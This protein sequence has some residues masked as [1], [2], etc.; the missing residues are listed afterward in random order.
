MQARE[1][2]AEIGRAFGAGQGKARRAESQPG[3][4]G[5]QRPAQHPGR[6]PCCTPALAHTAGVP[7]ST[8]AVA[9]HS[10]GHCHLQ[11]GTRVGRAGRAA[12]GG[13]G[14]RQALAHQPQ[15][16]LLRP[17]HSAPHKHDS[18]PHLKG[19]GRLQA[20]WNGCVTMANATT[21]SRAGG[22]PGAPGAPA[23]SSS[24]AAQRTA[25]AHCS[26]LH[27][28]TAAYRALRG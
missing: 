23:A 13:S 9:R 10:C 7:H 18:L 11:G 26:R 22:A 21:S 28:T 15:T 5:W 6:A 4:G 25:M 19:S 12:E 1:L 27:A 3:H 16:C 20:R 14:R 8:T 2:K 24:S 17:R